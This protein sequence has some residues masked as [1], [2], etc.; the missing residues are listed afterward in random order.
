MEFKGMVEWDFT[1]GALGEGA[2]TIS[3]L[4]LIC[5]GYINKLFI[6]AR[7]DTAFWRTSTELNVF[8]T[9]LQNLPKPTTIAKWK[10]SVPAKSFVFWQHSNLDIN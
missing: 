5:V 10:T 3:H 7:T 6:V 4:L 9:D 2:I 1:A 8:L